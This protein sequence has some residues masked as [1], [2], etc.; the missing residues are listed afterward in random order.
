MQG[1][2][3]DDPAPCSEEPLHHLGV[4]GGGWRLG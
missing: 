4:F 3:A 2:L 1:G